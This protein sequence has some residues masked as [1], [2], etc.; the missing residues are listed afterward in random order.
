MKLTL[1]RE[2]V[3]ERWRVI[4]KLGFTQ[5][6]PEIIAILALADGLPDGVVTGLDVS[7]KLLGERPAV[8]GERLLEVCCMM[9]LVERLDQPLE[10]WRLT[11]LGRRA[12]MNQEVPT[13]QRGEFDVWLMADELYPEALVRVRPTEP[14]T[15]QKQS[16]KVEPTLPVVTQELPRVLLQCEGHVIRPPLRLPDEASEVYV[17]EFAP[18][19]RCVAREPCLLSVE[20]HSGGGTAKFDVAF[21]GRQANF[22]PAAKLPALPEALKAAGRS[23]ADGPL[24]VAFRTLGDNERRSAR[25]EME[26]EGVAMPELG[27]FPRARL[28]DVRLVPESQQ[29][30]NEWA[31]WRLIDGIRGYVW[32]Q[33]FEKLVRQVRELAVREHWAF[34]PAMPSQAE[35]AQLRADLP[36]V[37]RRLLVP[38]DWQPIESLVAPVL[39]LSGRAAQTRHSHKL[40]KDWYEGIPR[41]YA[42]LGSD[43][44]NDG[45][46][47]ELGNRA[48]VRR[49]R[50][51]ADVWLRMGPDGSIG[52]RWHPAPKSDSKSKKQK[53]PPASDIEGEWK[54]LSQQEI[55]K[56]ADELKSGFW[57]R[58]THELQLDGRWVSVKPSAY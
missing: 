9:N 55:T 32:P 13:P 47:G 28:S 17:F 37:A 24:K 4:A 46:L 11:E 50:H 1:K 56:I 41:V 2:L 36:L 43:F 40:A 34:D 10:G 35:L 31:V 8:V 45:A 44:E 27:E 26:L 33:D 14:E 16:E 48:I 42:L 18:L 25:R 57:S 54:D 53:P 15:Q 23:E 6:R 30:A 49:V 29:D 21:A 51:P 52:Q 20:L 12:L 7:R 3:M 38:L 22:A 58:P 5:R 39:V 19:G